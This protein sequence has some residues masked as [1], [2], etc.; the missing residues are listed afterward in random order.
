MNGFSRGMKQKV[1]LISGL[2]H[3]PDIIFL[4]EPLAGLDANMV[5][6]V[7]HILVKLAE[8]G[9]TVFISSHLMDV[10]ERI[11]QRIVMLKDGQ[12]VADGS[13]EELKSSMNK[14]TLERIFSQM[15]ADYEYDDLS[16]QFVATL[17][18]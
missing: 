9:K 14:D 11:A 13:F 10:V 15:S 5:I 17:G 12:I 4:D 18:M 2:L 8:Q 7:K 16:D 1:L 6:L 3:N